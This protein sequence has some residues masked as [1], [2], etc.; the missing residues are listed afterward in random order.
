MRRALSSVHRLMKMKWVCL[1]RHNI[2]RVT[3][4]LKRLETLHMKDYRSII[5]EDL[6]EGIEI[7]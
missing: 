5:R 6:V 2:R 1:D 7:F 4:I 3:E